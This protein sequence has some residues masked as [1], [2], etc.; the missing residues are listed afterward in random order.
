MDRLYTVRILAHIDVNFALPLLPS[1]PG[2]SV[3]KGAEVRQKHR[4]TLVSGYAALSLHIV[5]SWSALAHSEPLCR[6]AELDTYGW[7]RVWIDS[8]M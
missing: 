6:M 1:G 8:R 3:V 4:M 2:D 7:R 5:G